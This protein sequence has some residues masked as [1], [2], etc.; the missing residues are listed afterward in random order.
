MS[1]MGVGLMEDGGVQV[2]SLSW[3]L[4]RK[5]SLHICVFICLMPQIL[6]VTTFAPAVLFGRSRLRRVLS[7]LFGSV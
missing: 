6:L 4:K 7:W 5:L 2:Q 1:W 3:C